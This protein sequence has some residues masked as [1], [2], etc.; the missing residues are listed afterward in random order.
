MDE[1]AVLHP[2]SVFSSSVRNTEREVVRTL[3][4]RGG[5][6]H[7]K[8]RGNGPAPAGKHERD[9]TIGSILA[10]A[11]PRVFPVETVFEYDTD[12]SNG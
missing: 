12:V 11:S 4:N 2:T 7:T 1:I 8:Q 9:W 3:P 5:V 6:Y 10:L